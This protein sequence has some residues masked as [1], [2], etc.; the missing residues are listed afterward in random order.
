MSPRNDTYLTLCL[1][2][3]GLSPLH[4]HHGSII[5]RG[6]KVLGQGF[7]SYRPSFDGSAL[8]TGILP[9]S[10]HDVPVIADLKPLLKSENPTPLRI[11]PLK[12]PPPPTRLLFPCIPK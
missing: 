10:P 7:N 2:Q 4:Y 8:K 11:P 6:G 3:A 1:A 9:S 5:V 12:I